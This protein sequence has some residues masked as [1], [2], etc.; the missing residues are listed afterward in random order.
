MLEKLAQGIEELK[1]VAE[2]GETD[3]NG[4][5][6]VTPNCACSVGTAP[7]IMT[8]VSQILESFIES[9]D[10]YDLDGLE[11]LDVIVERVKDNYEKK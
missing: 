6:I 1:K 4:F 11:A 3:K 5:I 8:L 9:F 10:K 7:T 2:I